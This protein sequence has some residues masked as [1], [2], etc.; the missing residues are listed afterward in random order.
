MRL[1]GLLLLVLAAP[2]FAKPGTP[3][4]DYFSGTYERIGR[5]GATPAGLVNDLVTIRPAGRS[6]TISGCAGPD[7]VL[8]FGPAFEIVNLMSGERAGVRVDCLF[9]NNGYNRPVLTCR[10]ED[11]ATFTLWPAEGVPLDAPLGC[12]G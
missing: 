4:P 10:G 5:D 2:A 3:G 6:V 11:G 1:A 7:L 8:G 12:D 9:H